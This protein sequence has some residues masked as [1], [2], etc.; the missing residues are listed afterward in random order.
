MKRKSRHLTFSALISVLV[1]LGLWIW[2]VNYLN[3]NLKYRPITE[4]YNTGEMV[5]LEDNY[6]YDPVEDPSGYYVRVD[7]ADIYHYEDFAKE[8]GLETDDYYYKST[9]IDRDSYVYVLNVTFRNTDNENGVVRFGCFSLLDK[10][11]LLN[12]DYTLWNQMEPKW[13]G[14]DMLRLKLN[15]E[16]S[17]RIPFTVN[18]FKSQLTYNWAMRNILKD[19]FSLCISHFPVRKLIVVDNI[20]FK[21]HE[22]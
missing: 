8:I 13:A 12:V 16:A 18:M 3:A 14:Y 2:R 11:L 9:A 1:L 17:L 22:L 20:T 10:S 15:S 4:N 7:S 19:S 6:L 5:P 21:E